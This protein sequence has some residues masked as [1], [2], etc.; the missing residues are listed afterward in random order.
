MFAKQ[1]L[2]K[3]VFVEKP[4]A[5]QVFVEQPLVKPVCLLNIQLYM[6]IQSHLKLINV[7]KRG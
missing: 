6:Q 2:A 3:P 7:K 1:P 4:Q 5:K